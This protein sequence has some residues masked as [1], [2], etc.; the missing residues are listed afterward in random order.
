MARWAVAL[1]AVMAGGVAATAVGASPAASARTLNLP[2]SVNLTLSGSLAITWQG[3]PTRGCAAE[4]LCG[5]RGELILRSYGSSGFGSSGPIS[6]L[7]IDLSGTVRA[8]D[9]AQ[10]PPADC[11]ELVGNSEVAPGPAVLLTHHRRWTA[12]LSPA[13]SSGRCAGPLASDLARLTL[14]VKVGGARYPIFDLHGT[15]EFSAGPFSGTAVS[16]MV[17]RTAPANGGSGGSFTESFS[18]A[19]SST[20]RLLTEFVALRYRVSFLPSTLE[21]S[22]AGAADPICQAFDS[23]QTT[24]SVGVTLNRGP[25]TITLTASRSVPTRVGARHVLDDLRAGRLTIDFPAFA[26]ARAE[27]TESL[28]RSNGSAC[29][30]ALQLS[31]LE[32]AFGPATGPPTIHTLPISLLNES[33]P[34]VDV[35]RTHCPGPA[36]TDVLGASSTL[37]ARSLTS[38][39]LLAHTQE[40]SLTRPGGFS[41]L[42]YS[43]ERSGAVKLRLALTQVVAGIR[44]RRP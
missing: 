18:A 10:S 23:C 41:G 37:A 6:E 5:V 22:F 20:H 36:E 8:R 27:L 14:P 44:T 19:S 1:A 17:V 43:G 13:P 31:G 32:V 34:G 29:A 24:G 28:K 38:R 21:A 25:A 7:S 2:K 12:V 4:G 33:G 9:D 3:D 40:I 42:G 11:V 35:L 16:T 39:E 26:S 15:R 30:E